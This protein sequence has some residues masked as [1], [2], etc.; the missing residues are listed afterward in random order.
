MPEDGALVIMGARGK[1][2]GVYVA[3]GI[4]HAVDGVGVVFDDLDSVRFLRGYGKLRIY[5]A[6]GTDHEREAQRL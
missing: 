2:V 3:N 6:H 4:L 5:K 1:H